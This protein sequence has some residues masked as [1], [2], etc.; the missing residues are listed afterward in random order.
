MAEGFEETDFV[1]YPEPP[2]EAEA[3]LGAL[4]TPPFGS[5]RR[6]VVI[7]GIEELTAQTAPWLLSY[8]E[9]PSSTACAL[10]CADRVEPG[11]LPKKETLIQIKDCRPLRGSVLEEWVAA[12]AKEIGKT[13]SR[14]SAALLIR[15]IGEN[16]Q[17][18]A[19]A[20]ES[21]GLLAGDSPR[22]GEAQVR[23]IIPPSVQETAFDILKT[24]ADGRKA[25]A[26]ESLRQ[27]TATGRLTLDQFFGAAG[28]YYRMAWKNRRIP[29][30]TLEKS[31]E[32]VLQADVRFKQGHPDPEML[33]E[34]L[35]LDLVKLPGQARLF[36]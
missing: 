36:S 16:L 24:A 9:Q 5:P 34:R 6:F 22:I 33:A 32:E 11:F 14:P 20:L 12:R 18:L 2:E 1:R 3:V 8:L 15:R 4:R 13:I 30:Q 27:A 35:L 19:L 31:L 28:W 26:M 17:G 21:L 10:L 23:A 25:Q 7:D 29:R